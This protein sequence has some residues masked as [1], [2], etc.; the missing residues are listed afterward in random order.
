MI[1]QQLADTARIRVAEDRKISRRC[2][3]APWQRRWQQS[4][5]SPSV[6]QSLIPAGDALYL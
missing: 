1:L 5:K 2:R 6:L 4:K 3:C